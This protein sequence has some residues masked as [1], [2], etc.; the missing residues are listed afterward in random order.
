MLINQKIHTN[1]NY[2]LLTD[3]ENPLGI[4]SSSAFAFCFGILKVY[5][6]EA[7]KKELFLKFLHSKGTNSYRKSSYMD[8]VKFCSNYGLKSYFDTVDL[9]LSE[10]K[11]RS[12]Y[13][14]HKLFLHNLFWTGEKFIG[15]G[16]TLKNSK[17]GNLP[18]T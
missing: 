15:K 2:S 4:G 3:G 7:Y 10:M 8:A 17:F 6:K 14:E 13:H 12:N 18:R 5:V 16:F 1:K 9:K 11:M